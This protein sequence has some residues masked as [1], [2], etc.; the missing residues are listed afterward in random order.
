MIDD[1][2]ETRARALA[3]DPSMDV[4]PIDGGFGVFVGWMGGVIAERPTEWE[5]WERALEIAKARANFARRSPSMPV[6]ERVKQ[7]PSRL[8]AGIPDRL[9]D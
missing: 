1:M 5:A 8:A 4:K 6:G 7:P 2:H 3:V 9:P